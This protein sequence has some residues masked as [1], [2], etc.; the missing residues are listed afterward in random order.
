[1][2]WRCFSMIFSKFFMSSAG[3][4]VQTIQNEKLVTEAHRHSG[5][6]HHWLNLQ[7]S[8]DNHRAETELTDSAMKSILL[9]ICQFFYLC[10][11][12]AARDESTRVC[13]SSAAG[14]YVGSVLETSSGTKY[15]SYQGLRSVTTAG[16]CN[17]RPHV[18][19][20]Q[21]LQQETWGSSCQR[22]LRLTRPRRSRTCRAFLTSS[23]SSTAS[24]E[25]T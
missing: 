7:W 8:E 5:Y 11:E 4:W 3:Y 22:S 20:M 17:H 23:A 12:E 2:T 16:Q 21:S 19:G 14:C 18:L 13:L 9:S 25:T 6:L 15:R 24:V 10:S 1:M